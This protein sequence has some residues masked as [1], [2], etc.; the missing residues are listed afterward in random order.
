MKTNFKNL[1]LNISGDL[2]QLPPIRDNL[3][4]DHSNLDGRPKCAPSQWQENFKIFYLTEKMRNQTDPRFAA[5]CDRVKIGRL[6]EEDID[7]FK[8]RIIECPSELQNESFK[9]GK[10]S[11]IVTTNAKKDLINREKL[12][13]LLPNQPEFECNSIDRSVNLPVENK[14][15]EQFKHNAG[16][17]G[18][19]ETQLRLKV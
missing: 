7:F 4:T 14:L 13:K 8:S 10:L 15:S 1:T 11:I 6:N 12:E 3:V 17:T 19:L 18:N 16:K 5:T 9:S 2:W